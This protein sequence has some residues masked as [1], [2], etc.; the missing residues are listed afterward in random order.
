MAPSTEKFFEA[1]IISASFLEYICMR[2]LRKMKF[3]K[4]HYED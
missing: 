4:G 2:N 1:L 3:Y